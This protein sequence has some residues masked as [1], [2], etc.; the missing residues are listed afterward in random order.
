MKLRFWGAV[1]TVTGSLH[2]LDV[3]G[4]RYILDCGMYQ[5]RRE[6]AF[7]RNRN[8]PVAAR[9][10]DGV[11]LS[12]AHIDHSGNLPS[13]SRAGYS[14]PVHATPATTDLC[15]YMLRDSAYLQEK[16]A[17]L[18]NKKKMRRK[19]IEGDG[20]NHDVEPLYSMDDAE[21]V[22][23]LFQQ[24]NYRQPKSL[25]DQL[26]F[27]YYDTGHLLGSA[28]VALTY[29]NNGKSIRLTFSGD[30]GRPGLPI[31][32]DPETMP[33][34]DYLI[35]ESTYGNRL[36]AQ[37]EVVR[38][39]LGGIINR[40]V[41]RGGRVIVP[42]FA[43]GRTQQLVLLLNQLSS[44]GE[45]P[46]IP[47][48]VDSPLAVNATEVYRRHPECYDEESYRYITDQ[49]DPLG[50]SRLRYI[51]D[52]NE[53]KALNGLRGPCVIISA[54]GMAEAGRILHHLRNN[55]EDP[56]NTVLIVGFQAE[57]T[58]GRKLIDGRTEVNIFGD[59]VR[60]RA[61][62]AK[63]NELS[64]HADQNGLLEWM[65]PMAKTLKGVF[66]VHGE[67]A[68][69]EPL[70]ALIRERYGVEAHIPTRGQVVELS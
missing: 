52:V 2:E 65:K 34:A 44:S 24:T 10:L 42:A 5:G 7:Q 57:N 40:T 16:D 59:P 70:A 45:I 32:R 20:R 4:Q 58:L 50:F 30:V 61:E 56:R 11:I 21:R 63:M 8:I 9:R 6:E 62:V 29:R 28:A 48:F 47:I 15:G 39:K 54:S 18:V 36:H 66:L 1:R 31:L 27:E 51:R 22:L 60:V 12:H 33:E 26:S 49:T 53:S 19:L 13:L 64:G 41:E 46:S 3:D 38:S 25:S 43:V 35:M 17:A 37:D 55:I 68:Q 69:A 23:T 14:G 67:V